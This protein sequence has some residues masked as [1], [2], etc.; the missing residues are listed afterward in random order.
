MTKIESLNFKTG[1]PRWKLLKAIGLQTSKYYEWKKRF[2]MSNQHNGKIP[3]D[4]WLEPWEKQAIVDFKHKHPDEGYKRLTYMMM[5]QDIV[6]VSPSTTYRYLRMAGL[7]SNWNKRTKPK[8]KGFTQPLKAHE[9]WHI[10]ISYINFRGTFLF[11]ICV[12]DGYSRFIVHHGLRKNMQEYDVQ[13]VVQEALEKYP[14]AKPRIISDNGPQFISKEFKSFIKFHGL[15]HVRT[16]VNHP[17][18]NGKIEAFH[19]NIKTECIRVESF[20]DL[21]DARAKVAEYILKYNHLRLHSGIGFVTPFDMLTGR[22]EKIFKE[23]DEK[24]QKARQRRKE[25]YQK[26]YRKSA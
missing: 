25:N 24:L 26:N 22:A 11:L 20:I 18:S 19:G 10:D 17:Q 15:K 2:G 21:E 6:A 4:F 5:D 9:H 8:K 3:R 7:T 23:R 13:L 12:L 1:V 16:S 14:H